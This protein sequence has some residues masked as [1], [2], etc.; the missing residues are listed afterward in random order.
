MRKMMFAAA[1]VSL[2]VF[3]AGCSKSED[4]E[5]KTTSD[6]SRPVA[7]IGSRLITQN[8]LDAETRRYISVLRFD[9]GRSLTPQQT[10]HLR[11]EVLNTLVDN[12]ALETEADRQGVGISSDELEAETRALLGDY[13]EATLKQTM[14]RSKTTLEEWKKSLAR[15]LKIRKLVSREVDQKIEVPDQELKDYFDENHSEFKWPERVRVSQIMVTDDASAYE[16]KKKLTSGD[17]FAMLAKEFSQS[18]DAA[19]GGDL[20]H[21]SKGQ[22]PPEFESAVFALKEGQASDVVKSSYGFHIFKL[23]KREPPRAMKFYEAKP[24]IAEVIKTEKREE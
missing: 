12:V 23:V 3:S 21:F 15:N 8:E 10:E 7:K 2:I 22:L 1:A 17:D 6:T 11:K 14:E 18:P 13:D 9:K 16:I 19:N 4:K 20:G 5:Q 24:N